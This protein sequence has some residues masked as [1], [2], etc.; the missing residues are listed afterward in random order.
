VAI[1]ALGA[2]VAHRA[3][4]MLRHQRDFKAALASLPQTLCH[5]DAAKSNLFVLDDGH[6]SQIVAIDWELVGTGPLGADI[7][8]LISGSLRKGEFPAERA[9]E[10]DVAVRS[11]YIEGLRTEGWTGD[12]GAVRVGLNAS[13]A[14]RYWFIRDALR[15]L[16]NQEPRLPDRDAL[17][18][19]YLLDR[20]DDALSQI[21]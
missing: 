17:I 15:K 19:R 1:D 18:S 21:S 4:R 3:T 6:E 5:H 10:L 2:D 16:S 14:L 11:A 12:D 20:S 13:L 9:E 7:A 8:T